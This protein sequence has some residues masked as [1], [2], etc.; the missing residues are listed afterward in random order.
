MI[1]QT[2]IILANRIHS[3]K[4]LRSTAL[5][6]KDIGIRKSEFVTKTQFLLVKDFLDEIAYKKSL[7]YNTELNMEE[8]IQNYSQAVMFRRT[9]CT[10]PYAL[11]IMNSSIN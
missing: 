2:L 3:L 7:I 1:F 6:L 5:G 8:D 4:Y 10:Y 9:P 11:N